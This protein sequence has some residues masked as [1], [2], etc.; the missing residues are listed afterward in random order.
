VTL[1]TDLTKEEITTIKDIGLRFNAAELRQ[2]L[3][4]HFPGRQFNSKL[5]SNIITKERRVMF[6]RNA[7]G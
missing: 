1:K 3:Q 7:G 4:D 6:G 2:Y 5:L